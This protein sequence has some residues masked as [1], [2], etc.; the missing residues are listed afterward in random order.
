M[1]QPPSRRRYAIVPPGVRRGAAR[2][3]LKVDA[4]CQVRC[5]G[6]CSRLFA[7]LFFSQFRGCLAAVPPLFRGCSAAVPD[8]PLLLAITLILHEIITKNPRPTRP[9]DFFAQT[10][11]ICRSLP[12]AKAS[13]RQG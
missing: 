13:D 5:S 9:Q 8:R 4:R 12:A 2:F 10:A 11:P 3:F 6:H 1:I 7:A